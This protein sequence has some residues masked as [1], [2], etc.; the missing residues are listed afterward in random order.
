MMPDSKG[1][2]LRL[3]MRCHDETRTV[4]GDANHPLLDFPPGATHC[5]QSLEDF[6]GLAAMNLPKGGDGRISSDTA[7]CG[8]MGY[9]RRG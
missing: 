4:F 6:D 8:L 9:A 5:R 3:G 7:V 1:A 2:S